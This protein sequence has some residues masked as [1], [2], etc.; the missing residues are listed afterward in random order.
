MSEKINIYCQECNH[1]IKSFYK[2]ELVQ[3]IILQRSKL[4]IPLCEN[5]KIHLIAQIPLNQNLST[6]LIEK[7]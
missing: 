2:T 1:L 4:H 5:C 6:E 3:I 7:E